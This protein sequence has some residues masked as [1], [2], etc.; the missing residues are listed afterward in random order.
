MYNSLGLRD[1]QIARETDMQ[2]SNPGKVLL[3]SRE[4]ALF[5]CM[6][7]PSWPYDLLREKLL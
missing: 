6:Y 3:H 7:K 5:L 4:G 2:L 1:A